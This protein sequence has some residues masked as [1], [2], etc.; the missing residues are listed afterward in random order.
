MDIQ[1][2]SYRDYIEDY[3][4]ACKRTGKVTDDMLSNSFDNPS[5]NIALLHAIVGMQS[6]L[7]ELMDIIRKKVFYGI[8]LDVPNI[9]EEMGD[10]L[11][12]WNL[13]Q[14]QLRKETCCNEINDITAMDLNRK[15]LAVRY[16]NGYSIKDSINR[17]R[18]AERAIFE[19]LLQ[20]SI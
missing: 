20:N 17:D 8:P 10:F 9:I 11:Y 1:T 13:L 4:E 18:K 5:G 14:D 7:G 6:E 15:K 16:P 12:Y 19:S 3:V 2:Q